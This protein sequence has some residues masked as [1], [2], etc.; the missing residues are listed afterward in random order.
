MRYDEYSYASNLERQQVVDALDHH[1]QHLARDAFGAAIFFIGK[2][3]SVQWDRRPTR[4]RGWRRRPR[5]PQKLSDA[6]RSSCRTRRTPAWRD[7]V[8]PAELLLGLASRL[9]ACC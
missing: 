7:L 9:G 6:W 2:R 4:A 8:P 5:V 3:K 1:H